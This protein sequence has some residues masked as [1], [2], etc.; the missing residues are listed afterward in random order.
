MIE[1]KFIMYCNPNKGGWH[2]YPG[3]WTASDMAGL[4]LDE[5]NTM[6]VT[7]NIGAAKI[8]LTGA[9]EI[10]LHTGGGANGGK[11]YI[12]NIKLEAQ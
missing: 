2:P 4:P 6:R 11:F 5:N 1:G 8:D 7:H 12:D 3:N 9:M 10:N